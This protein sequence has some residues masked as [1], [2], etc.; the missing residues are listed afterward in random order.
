M[1]DQ[2]FKTEISLQGWVQGKPAWCLWKCCYMWG[3]SHFR[4]HPPR[5][6]FPTRSS[7]DFL[8]LFNVSHTH[9]TAWGSFSPNVAAE[10]EWCSQCHALLLLQTSLCAPFTLS[11][12]A[13]GCQQPAEVKATKCR[14]LHSCQNLTPLPGVW[15]LGCIFWLLSRRHNGS[16]MQYSCTPKSGST[17]EIPWMALTISLRAGQSFPVLCYETWKQRNFLNMT[18]T[19]SHNWN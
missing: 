12:T 7:L 6:F 14:K 2:L 9:S 8:F 17:N 15:C 11:S 18:D 13:D 5:L 10:W 3:H 1:L 4:L 16:C 19:S